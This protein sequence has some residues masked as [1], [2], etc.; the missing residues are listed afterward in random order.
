MGTIILTH[1]LD[2]QYPLGCKWRKGHVE[3][4]DF[5]F[6]GARS[7]IC[8]D[9]KIGR[10]CIIGAGS[11]VTKDIPDNEIWCGN[12]ARFIKRCNIGPM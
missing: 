2:T 12:P 4:G 6:V 11:I 3:I 7:I 8:N 5:T 1:N 10:N 9:V